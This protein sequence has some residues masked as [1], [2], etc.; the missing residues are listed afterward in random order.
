MPVDQGVTKLKYLLIDLYGYE[1]GGVVYT[2]L[3]EKILHFKQNHSI[4][5]GIARGLIERDAILI[6]YGDQVQEDGYFP[7]TSLTEFCCQHLKG[8]VNGLH[9]LPFFPYSSDDGFSVI[10]YFQVDP[11]LGNWDEITRLAQ[12]FH[13][14]FDAVVNHISVE[15]QWFKGYLQGQ[16]EYQNYFIEVDPNTDLSRVVRPRALPLLTAF[17]TARGKR[18]LW[19]TFSTDQVDLNFKHPEVLL[20]ILDVLLF[21]VEKGAHFI[22]LDAIAYIWKEIGTP[23]IHLM[24]THRIIQVMRIILDEV[25]PY[26]KIITETN[27]PHRDNISYFGDGSNEAHLVYNFALPPLV[28]HS[29]LSGEATSISAWAGQLKPAIQGVTFFNFLASHDG[30]GLNPARDILSPH[31]ID[32]L[33][34]NTLLS[35]GEVS[36]KQ[37][38]DGSHSPYELN[39]NYFDALNGS[40]ADI[41]QEMQVEKFITAHAIMLALCGVPGLYFH[42]LFGSRG[43]RDGVQLTGRKRTINRQKLKRMELEQELN[44]ERSLR[45]QVFSRMTA[46]IKARSAYAEFNPYGEQKIFALNPAVFSVLRYIEEGERSIFCLHNVSNQPQVVVIDI[47][48]RYNKPFLGIKEIISRQTLV[49]NKKAAI[50]L[51]PYQTRWLLLES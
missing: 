41:P 1:T 37:N 42:S 22:R 15:S 33:V 23:C 2:R 5:P 31:E 32:S 51:K 26:V 6:T 24:Q 21:Y 36:Y 34:K 19:T 3:Q 43:W 12:D 29:L 7:L 49:L 40:Q 45:F 35:G 47:S 46:L 4:D 14:M 8:I 28:L 50:T 9:I 30:I 17:D 11:A 27:V 38:P 13:L 10:D 44:D 20:K 39:I 18:S 25:A 48:P 16:A